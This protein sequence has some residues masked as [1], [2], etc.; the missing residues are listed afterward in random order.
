MSPFP[1]LVTP[2]FGAQ[3]TRLH[4]TGED[5]KMGCDGI[6]VRLSEGIMLVGVVRL[7]AGRFCGDAPLTGVIAEGESRSTAS[8]PPRTWC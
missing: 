5:R 1:E 8:S 7:T 4:P 3:V 2:C 6:E